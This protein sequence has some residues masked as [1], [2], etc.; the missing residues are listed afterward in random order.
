[1]QDQGFDEPGGRVLSDFLD[2][3]ST[4][5]MPAFGKLAQEFGY[6]LASKW[7]A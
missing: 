1:M 4:R 5:L 7:Y 2:L 3:A 6:W